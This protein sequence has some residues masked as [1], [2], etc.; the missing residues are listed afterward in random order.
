MVWDTSE[1]ELFNVSLVPHLA[2]RNATGLCIYSNRY[3][4]S[5]WDIPA[6]HLRAAKALAAL[7]ERAGRLRKPAGFARGILRANRLSRDRHIRRVHHI[8]KEPKRNISSPSSLPSPASLS[9]PTSSDSDAR[10]VLRCS[11]STLGESVAKSADG[12][13]LT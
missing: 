3:M 9:F 8:P 4:E 2:S 7:R 6:V 10:K 12:F 13:Q 5:T 11:R 1:C